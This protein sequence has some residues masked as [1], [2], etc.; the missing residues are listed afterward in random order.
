M[1]ETGSEVRFVDDVQT[2]PRR[3]PPMVALVGPDG[4]GKSTIT[5]RLESDQ[6]P[7][8]V[9]R[10]YMGVNLEASTDLLPTT[11][12]LLTARE[13]RRR[14]RAWRSRRKRAVSR[15]SDEAARQP[16]PR[17]ARRRGAKR[18]ARELKDSGRLVL[19][20]IEEWLRLCLAVFHRSRGRVV[21][22]DRHFFVDYH[23]SS[24]VVRESAPASPLSRLHQWLLV[25][26]YP[27]PDL[28]IC[29]DAPAAVLRLRK[30][31]DSIEWLEAR[32]AQYQSLAQMV[33]AF[34][35][36]DASRPVDQV[37]AEVVSIIHRHHRG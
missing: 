4:V 21:V 31:E 16:P 2:L 13:F 9:K 12:V 3:R 26:V 5:R 14:A 10:M 35:L 37:Y 22:F 17:R 11:R 1:T 27:R 8:A 32:R 15:V 30:R 36:V 28:V 25:H 7:Y 34:A 19:W 23:N 20:I 6:L 18:A 24:G 33:P 29:L